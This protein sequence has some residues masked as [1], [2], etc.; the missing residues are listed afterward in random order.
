MV[1]P[2]HFPT[3]PGTWRIALL[4]GVLMAI[5]V[6]AGAVDAPELPDSWQ[7]QW[8]PEVGLWTRQGAGH[9]AP[10]A[11]ADQVHPGTT[12]A[13]RLVAA[14]VVDRL[15][16]VDGAAVLQALRQMQVTDGGN[17]HGCL[18]WYW[19]EPRPVDT[20]AAFFTG[21]NLI[22]LRLGFPDQLA[23]WA[24]ETRET[25]DAILADLS[26]WFD[27]TL[28][29]PSRYYPNKYMGDLVCRWLLI[30]ALE[31]TADRP[32]V[33]REM[34]ASAQYWQ[35]ENWGWGEH[36]SNIYATVLLDQISMLLQLSR[37]LPDTVRR[38]YTKL[39]DELL[40]IED[41]YGQGPRVP[42][43]RDYHFDRR[44]SYA[45]YRD[46]V[47]SPERPADLSPG[48]LAMRPVL[49]TL[50]W[51]RTVPPRAEPQREIIV[52]CFDGIRAVAHV[53]GPVRLGTLSRFPLMPQME[54]PTWG[55]SWQSFP[56][57][58][59]H[60]QGGWGFLQW[61]TE[62]EGQ[63]RAHPAERRAQ[64]YLRNAL[65]FDKSRPIVGRTWSV[66]Q[67]GEAIVLRVMPAIYEGWDALVDR[68][69]LVQ[70]AAQLQVCERQGPWSQ[71]VLDFGE[72]AVSVHHIS[73]DGRGP[74]MIANDDAAWDWQIT[75]TA[76]DLAGRPWV[77]Q[78]WS[79]CLDGH[80]EHPP[81]L[82]RVGD[83]DVWHLTWDTGTGQPPWQLVIDPASEEPL[84]TR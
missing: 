22:V 21:L 41:A 70:P 5:A 39:R 76:D 84:R 65:T 4:A 83:E 72:T 36:M 55:L 74:E 1:F 81:Q 42:M 67:G 77:A 62:R 2:R 82:E 10:V 50:G 63:W 20:N 37:D 38:E 34:L 44:P 52:P 30:E 12:A 18:K 19:E 57:A 73:L 64:A 53:K 33:S 58:L 59:W 75:Y 7:R 78:L 11:G 68:F 43:I 69:R 32:R 24:P 49:A 9:T 66:Q 40:A 6:R 79:L 23:Q 26:V 13:A 29:R 45:N 71:I 8:N 47:R 25:L 16:E 56:V 60:E 61:A 48:N 3:I 27:Q 51:D 46:R 31:Q 35:E 17:R 54:H 15:H 28:E 14:A 80:L